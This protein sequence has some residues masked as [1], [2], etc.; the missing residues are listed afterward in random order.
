M[1]KI[2]PFFLKQSAHTR[3]GRHTYLVQGPLKKWKEYFI[4]LQIMKRLYLCAIITRRL[5]I[6]N[7]HFEDQK[8]SFKGLFS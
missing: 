5:Y 1:E 2:K 7:P 3:R 4:K 8:H 6:L